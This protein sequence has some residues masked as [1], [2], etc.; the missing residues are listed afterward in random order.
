MPSLQASRTNSLCISLHKC[1]TWEIFLP[2]LNTD[3]KKAI[4]HPQKLAIASWNH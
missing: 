4:A 2:I 1:L 3:T